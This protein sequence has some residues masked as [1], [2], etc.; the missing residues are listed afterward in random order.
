MQAHQLH[1]YHTPRLSR[2]GLI[3]AFAA[4]AVVPSLT[5]GP[6]QA[7]TPGPSD[8]RATAVAQVPQSA[9]P[10]CGYGSSSG[11]TY[12]CITIEGSGLHVDYMLA[13]ADVV[14][15]GR[16]LKVCIRGPKGT[17]GCFPA[18]SFIYVRKGTGIYFEWAPNSNVPAGD[19][20]ANTWRLNS[21]GSDTEIGHECA[22]V[23]A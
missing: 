4:S 18:N 10:R 12:T 7:S 5:V 8:G 17:V 15:A 1:S 6:A 21:N 11:N 13:T 19:Y 3:A 9:G 16:R 23:H 22:N 20:C 14:N 2:M